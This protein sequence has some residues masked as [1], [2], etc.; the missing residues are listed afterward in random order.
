MGRAIL[1]VAVV[2]GGLG[3]AS[4][5]PVAS[6]A[7]KVRP[8]A[9]VDLRR[10]LGTWYEIASIPQPFQRDCSGPTDEYSMR[11]DGQ[12]TVVK[13]CR[14]GDGLKVGEGVARIIDRSSNS[15]LEVSFSGPFWE[16]YWII[17]LDRDY[18]YAVVGDQ[19]RGTLTVLSREPTLP[20]W[21]FAAIMSRAMAQGYDVTRVKLA[22]R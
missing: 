2:F 5:A 3:C 6:G 4:V 14:R 21:T 9:A 13:R 17:D 7:G 18:T 16:D 22:E 12:L 15:R 11:D 1:C 10:Y 8:V 19:K 20:S